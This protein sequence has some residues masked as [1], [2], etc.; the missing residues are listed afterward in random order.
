MTLKAAELTV[1][2]NAEMT[3]T[4]KDIL[5][6]ELLKILS[7]PAVLQELLNLLTHDIRLKAGVRDRAVDR[8]V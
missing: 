8:G 2:I 4:S 5:R 7:E 6:N 1:K 3:E